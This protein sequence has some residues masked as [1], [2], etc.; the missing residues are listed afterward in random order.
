[1]LNVL[2]FSMNPCWN[3]PW[4]NTRKLL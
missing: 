3:V 1:L 4:W 2:R